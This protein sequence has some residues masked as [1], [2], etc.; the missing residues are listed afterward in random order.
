MKTKSLV[1]YLSLALCY[2]SSARAQTLEW[3]R[4]LGTSDTDQ[5]NGV[6]A[7]GLGNVYISGTDPFI[8]KYDDSGTLQWTQQLG[9]SSNG[10]SADGL[11]NV[12]ISGR[13]DGSLDGNNAGSSDAFVK[14]V[15]RQRHHG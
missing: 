8:S 4:Q 2:A 9:S 11:G 3:T 5:S 12:Y 1:A 6:S 15:R 10:V 7:D 13:T 14:Q